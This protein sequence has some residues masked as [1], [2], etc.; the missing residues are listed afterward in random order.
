MLNIHS[1]AVGV[2]LLAY[3]G[4]AYS[5]LFILFFSPI[6]FLPQLLFYSDGTLADFYLQAELWTN[7][8]YAG[9]P[10]F[11]TPEK[12]YSYPLR[13]IFSWLPQAM[14]FNL[15]VISAYVMASVFTFGYVYRLTGAVFPA[16]AAGLI[17]GLCGFMVENSVHPYMIHVA[18]WM[19]LLL[20]A[21]YELKDGY[22]H[23]W[24]ITGCGAVG[25][26]VVAGHPQITVYILMLAGS[27]M[28]CFCRN[29]QQGWLKYARLCLCLVVLGFGLAAVQL[30]PMFELLGLSVRNEITY[31]WFSTYSLPASQLA[32][33]FF[34]FIYGGEFGS[35]YGGPYFGDWYAKGITGNVGVFALLLS[36]F[37]LIRGHYDDNKAIMLFWLGCAIV[38]FIIGLGDSTPLMPLL[39][40]VPIFNLFRAH[41]RILMVTSFAIAILAGLGIHAL[42][43]RV[44][45]F[46]VRLLPSVFWS[47]LMALTLYTIVNSPLYQQNSWRLTDWV[48]T[49]P[50]VI[51]A[52]AVV[53]TLLWRRPIESKWGMLLVV[54]YLAADLSSSSWFLQWQYKTATSQI[55]Q[56]N[57]LQLKYKALLQPQHQRFAPME[58]VIS[59]ILSPDQARLHQF[60]T[61][62]A[63][64]P[65]QISRYNQLSGVD[66]NGT[67]AA[68]GLLPNSRSLDLL[69]VKYLSADK[70]LEN[71]DKRFEL[72]NEDDGIYIYQNLRALPRAWFVNEV[73]HAT[74]AQISTAI[75]TSI[76]PDGRVF[77]PRDIA[78]V[79]QPVAKK[80][81]AHSSDDEHLAIIKLDS[82]SIEMETRTDSRRFMVL[83]DIFYPG[84][85]AYID[86]NEVE[87]WQTNLSLRGLYIPKGKHKVSFQYQPTSFIVGGMI[88]LLSSIVLLWLFIRRGSTVRATPPVGSVSC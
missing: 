77:E 83:S 43:S 76:L 26:S 75:N 25:M 87:I 5:C 22:H 62:T 73:Y 81:D 68:T 14:G 84:W 30:L 33:S 32:Q 18:A 20:W 51:M 69:A 82:Q 15:F 45:N 44:T 9:Y 13:F 60:E 4:L 10:V 63:Y 39:Y 41:G 24:F 55:L 53:I 1:P 21:L 16:F 56:P 19:P 79:E 80:L 28:L 42:Q 3:A 47:L 35:F 40:E 27:Y 61:T 38:S 52:I 23:G 17:Y 58:G 49:V 88:S 6:V 66:S 72:M 48:M 31:D 54:V 46:S 34:P 74:P 12:Q 67:L 86:G 57:E 50:V 78:L 37:A 71:L 36:S 65:L 64:A 29:A 11:A 7:H 85:K 59:Q 8:F 2:K 70:P